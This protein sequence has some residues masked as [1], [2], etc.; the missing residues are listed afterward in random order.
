[1]NRLIE[2][3][4]NLSETVLDSLLPGQ[5]WVIVNIAKT[6]TQTF[7]LDGIPQIPT[8]FGYVYD[9]VP[10]LLEKEGIIEA[11]EE[12]R[13]YTEVKNISHYMNDD[14]TEIAFAKLREL[15]GIT[16]FTR[17]KGYLTEDEIVEYIDGSDRVNFNRQF[18]K[19]YAVLM[20]RKAMEQFIGW[21]RG[22]TPKFDEKTGELH[23]LGQTMKFSGAITIKTVKLL[24]DNL[25]SFVSKKDFYNLRGVDNYD[26]KIRLKKLTA[27]HDIFEKSIKDI[28]TTLAKNPKIEEALTI[29]QKDGFGIFMNK[30]V[31][32]SSR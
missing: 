7:A 13:W 10:E 11:K 26:T 18:G 5:E 22:L 25:N 17:K 16:A 14:F 31:M 23:F 32:F 20:N 2:D 3:A 8:C 1:M 29:I 12:N 28:K 4:I 9:R 21:Y 30:K 19:Q 6:D 24:M 15:D 27:I